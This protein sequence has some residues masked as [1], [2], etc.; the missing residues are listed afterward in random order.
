MKNKKS[1]KHRITLTIVFDN[2]N[3]SPGLKT[4]WGYSC[5]IQNGIDTIL[6]DTGSKGEILLQNMKQLHINAQSVGSVII[7]HDHW[8]HTGGLAD[9]LKVNPKVKV[10]I[11]KSFSNKAEDGIIKAGAEVI[12][13]DSFREVASGVFSLGELRE[14]IPEQSLAIRTAKGIVLLT[15]CAHPGIVNIIKHARF[16]FSSEQF[17]LVMGGFHLKNDNKEEAEKT[18]QK[19]RALDVKYV[20]PSHCTGEGAINNF[21]EIFE[22]QF[23]ES[24]VGRVIEIL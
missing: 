10:F 11:P 5:V 22:D 7:S 2:I 9:F 13:V 24:G 6:F 21:V 14:N 8:D 23:I 17:Y 20:A 1:I 4:E 18:V 15:G 12:R 3:Y 16:I 19:I